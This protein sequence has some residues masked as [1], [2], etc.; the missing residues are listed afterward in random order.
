MLS[1]ALDMSLQY[2]QVDGANLAHLELLARRVM[3]IEENHKYR[4]PQMGNDKQ[5]NA[6][7]DAGL[8]L[9]LGTAAMAGRYAIAV[10]PAL[11]EFIGE[12]L[13]KEAN[14][15]KGRLKAFEYW[16]KFKGSKTDK[17]EDTQ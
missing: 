1:K 9:G 7:A 12:E 17:K 16:Q 10:M 11:A 15:N 14:I 4:M 2:D 13:Q 5:I 6:E 8:F 3:L